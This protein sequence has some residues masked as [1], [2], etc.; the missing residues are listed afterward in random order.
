MKTDF[1][2]RQL[3]AASL[4]SLGILGSAGPLLAETYYDHY[5]LQ[6]ASPS[7]ELGT[8]PLGYPSGVISAVMMRD[9][10]LAEAL[11]Q[12]G[13]P[14]RPHAFQRGADMLGLFAGHRLDAGLLGDVPTILGASTGHLLIVGLVKQ[15]STA[16]VARGEIQVSG[17]AGK[18]IGYVEASSAHHTLLQGLASTKLKESNVT[19]VAMRVDDMPEAL[20]RGEIDAF[21]AWEPAPSTALRLSNKNRIVFRGLSSDYFVISRS[22]EKQAPEAARILVAGYV[23]AIEWMRRSQKNADLAAHWAITDAEKFSSKKTSLPANQIVSITR[24]EI[25]NVPSAPV[26]I[27][28]PGAPLP[29]RSEF[30]FLKGQNKL[31]AEGDWENVVTAL[32]YNGLERVMSDQRRYQTKRFDYAE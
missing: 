11:R 14:L 20:M 21:A 1:S 18:R 29:L 17:L 26:I 28:S 10:I 22:F 9:R 16:I 5:G 15:S 4:L 7:L 23:R 31:P 19:L 27:S 13:H 2:W 25:L 3:L 8:Q 32:G 6:P 12:A 30:T 24:R